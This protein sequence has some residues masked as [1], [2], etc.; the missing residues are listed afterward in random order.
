MGELSPWQQHNSGEQQVIAEQNVLPTVRASQL[1]KTTLTFL[2]S[3]SNSS[4][5]C[6]TSLALPGS[7]PGGKETQDTQYLPV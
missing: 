5:S 7:I 6:L 2:P 3:I 4:D 1:S